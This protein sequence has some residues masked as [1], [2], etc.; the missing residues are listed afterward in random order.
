MNVLIKIIIAFLL[1]L[2]SLHAQN[3]VSGTITDE[4][5]QPLEFA[6]ITLLIN[7][8]SIVTGGI[9]DKKGTFKF[10]AKRGNYTF[11]VTYV[12]QILY[13]KQITVAEESINLGV[14]SV[15]SSQ[16]LDEV[17]VEAKKKLIQRKIDRLVF[18][19]E[20]SSKASQGDALEVLRVTPAIRVQNNRIMMIGKSSLQ[21]MVND[22]IVQLS[23]EDLSEFLKS[24]A[25]E[26]IKNIEVITTPPAKYEAS[27][28]SGLVNITL[29]QVKKDSWNAQLKSA[30]RQQRYSTGS[31][32]GNF[33]FNK[34]KFSIATSYNYSNGTYYQE[35]D[36]YAYFPDGLWYTSSPFKAD[37]KRLNGRIDINYQITS[38]WTMGGQ[39]LYNN[40]NFGVTDTP[41][42]PVFDYNT[43]ET[44][45]SLQS[46]GT[47]DLSPEIHSLNY[48]NEVAIDTLGRKITF[49]LDYFAYKNPDTKTY[50]GVSII[51]NPFS[52]QFYRGTNTNKQDVTNVSA[53]LDIEYP[54][55]RLDLSFGG[56][57]SNSNSL[58]DILFFNSGLVNAPVTNLP[59]S[60]NDFHYKENI[61][62]LYISANKNL[63][64]KWSVQFGLRMEATQTNSKSTNL[65]ISVKNNYTKLFPTFYLS[66]SATE[67]A[68]FSFNYS[69][70]IDR[71]S[72]F[73]LNPNLYFVNPFQTIE[74]NA[75]LQPA[76]IDNFELINTY[77]NFVTKLYYSY[78]DNL[79]SQ[80]PL[81]DTTTN[82]IRFTNENF[83]NTNRIGF[84]ENYSFNKIKW[85]SSSNSF[86]VNYSKSEFNLEEQQ[87]DQK[88]INATIS[89]YNDFNVN[90]DK[91]LLLGVYFWYSFPGVNGIFN[92]KSASSLSLSLQ[93]LLLKK[94]LNIS[95]RGNDI[96]KS[97]AE[98]NESR[99]NG[100]FQTARYY[101]DSRSFQL[102]VSYKFGNKNIKAKRH[103][104][105]NT[106]EKGRTGN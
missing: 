61:Q 12:G 7:Q 23:D 19:V 34:D 42:T 93:Y 79:F 2:I 51:K 47:M 78:E 98:R 43:N 53:K 88:G 66:Y 33:N 80:V 106:A 25:S 37:I 21:V 36:D 103:Q 89:T 84:S 102:S 29:K 83:I 10:N 104:T 1:S 30:Y 74:G 99:V 4:N 16:E 101:Y 63:N 68:N 81:A 9:T 15:V 45:R 40:I 69:K 27:G 24:I 31:F 22:K 46:D 11:Q 65:N 57:I 87:E 70:R 97:S 20:N 48:N 13:T 72:F 49:N 54:L 14:I 50:N 58:N 44:L 6:E 73:E 86:D 67:N 18:N 82:I 39:Y 85:W 5:K 38:K 92:T 35:Q 26:D 60:E 95:L 77:K 41:F 32:G 62:A 75:F 64:D 90:T 59:L 100:V 105:G 71:P 8:S 3:Q 96:F 91:T 76:F 28:N 55:N 94:D 52:E 56:K 17:V